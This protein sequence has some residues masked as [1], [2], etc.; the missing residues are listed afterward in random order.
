MSE[1]EYRPPIAG[2]HGM[3]S[4]GHS[5]ASVA[6]VQILQSGGNAFDAG[7]TTALALNIL[8]PDYAGFVGVAP[9]TG[10]SAREG[11]VVSYSGLGVTFSH[12]DGGDVYNA[13]TGAGAS[14]TATN[15]YTEPGYPHGMAS[16]SSS[17]ARVG[18]FNLSAS[19]TAD[20]M[21]VEAG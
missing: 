12:L 10:Y 9:F 16:F 2:T 15:F 20:T 7:V 18:L 14:P 11:K 3:V 21:A 4:S 19:P 13:G 1:I 5:L 17:I 6:G 8:L